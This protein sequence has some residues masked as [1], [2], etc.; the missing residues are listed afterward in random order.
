MPKTVQTLNSKSIIEALRQQGFS[1]IALV[2]G[3]DSIRDL[4]KESGADEH[5]T[6][7]MAFFPF[8]DPVSGNDSLIAPFARSNHYK[9]IVSRMK[10]ALKEAGEPFSSLTRR[11]V[12]FFSNSTL[13]EKELAVKAG[14][15]F[16]GRNT[17][18]INREYGSRG[19][20]GGIII[21][22]ALENSTEAITTGKES[23]GNCRLCEQA[24]PGGALKDGQLDRSR[25]LQHWSTDDRAIPESLKE[26]WGNRIYGCTI[27]QDICPWNRRTR[28]EGISIDRGRLEPEP[29]LEFYLNHSE[30]EIKSRLKGSALGMGWIKGCHLIR[31][32]LVSAGWSE[33]EDLLPLIENHADADNEIIR[34]AAL[35]TIRKI[36]PD[37]EP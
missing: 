8:K 25:C 15:G 11:E 37:R 2:P 30:E 17:L 18:I 14:L 23:C 21:P 20:L 10:Q 35:W 9:E 1:R 3:D 5:S 33:R 12:R 22:F 16:Q 19:L 29:E 36:R 31:N 26:V 28:P 27:C 7:I 6:I 32:A 13:P 34:D 24:C 4:L